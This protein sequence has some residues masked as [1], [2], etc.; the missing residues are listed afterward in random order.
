MAADVCG[1]CHGEPLRHSR[2]QQ[3]QG[4][5]HGPYDLAISE[6]VPEDNPA[7]TKCAGC[8]TAQ[9]FLIYLSRLNAGIP[10]RTLPTGSI[11]WTSSTV[12]PI[13][14]QVCHDPHAEGAS[15]G[16]PNTATVRVTDNTPKLP[17]GFAATGV[18]RG[19]VCHRLSQLSER[20]SRQRF[21]P[22]RGRRSE[23]R[24]SHCLFRTTRSRARAMCSWAITRISSGREIIAL[25]IR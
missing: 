20:R 4:S 11:F 17:G 22:A 10:L 16:V 23:I 15:S 18:G 19:A 7:R 25:L 13:T 9:G 3:W 8:H 12:D 14:C 2:F 24:A 5:G 6:G 1:S 21:L